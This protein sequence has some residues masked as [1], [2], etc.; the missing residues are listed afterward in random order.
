MP[1]SKAR[2]PFFENPLGKQPGISFGVLR[3]T[4]D[5]KSNAVSRFAGHKARLCVRSEMLLPPDAPDLYLDA[6][7]HWLAYEKALMPAQRDLAT[8]ITIYMPNARTLHSAW[9]EVRSFARAQFVEERHLPVQLVLHAP[10][11]SGSTND[12]H[13]HLIAG[14]RQ[15]RSWGWTTFSDLLIDAAQKVVWDRWCDHQAAWAE[16]LA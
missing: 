13:L 15:L 3:S 4:F 6:G 11:L 9:E 5:G 1:K 8:V 14:A 10:G 12:T 16:R 7:A 2:H